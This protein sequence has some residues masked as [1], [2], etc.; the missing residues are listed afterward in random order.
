LWGCNPHTPGC[1]AGADGV[2]QDA[3]PAQFGGQGEGQGVQ[4]RLGHV[5]ARGTAG[6]SQR[7][8]SRVTQAAIRSM[9]A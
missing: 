5:V 9:L 4:R 2:D 7:P 1:P 8:S 6:A 3:V